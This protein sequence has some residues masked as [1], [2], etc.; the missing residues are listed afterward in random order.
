MAFKETTLRR[1]EGMDVL[2]PKKLRRADNDLFKP[3]RLLKE[4]G[5]VFS[6]KLKKRNHTSPSNMRCL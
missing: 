1:K 2:Y 4:Q 6:R 3:K 5:W